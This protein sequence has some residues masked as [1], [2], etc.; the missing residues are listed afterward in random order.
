MVMK[1]NP[2]SLPKKIDNLN[3]KIKQNKFEQQQK[4]AARE[5]TKQMAAS[6]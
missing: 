6:Q 3:E 5:K 1:N 2:A 4:Y